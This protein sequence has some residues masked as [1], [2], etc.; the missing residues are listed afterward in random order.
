MSE[1]SDDEDIEMLEKEANEKG[2]TLSSLI[3]HI[4][5]KFLQEKKNKK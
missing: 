3:R 4:V 1:P 5:K 2:Y